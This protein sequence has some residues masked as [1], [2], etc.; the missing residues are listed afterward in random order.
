[1]ALPQSWRIPLGS[2]LFV[3]LDRVLLSIRGYFLGRLLF[4]NH[5]NYLSES[6][7][8]TAVVCMSKLVA[9]MRACRAFQRAE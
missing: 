9:V 2:R 7:L 6:A 5:L 1:M 8:A 3:L 4:S